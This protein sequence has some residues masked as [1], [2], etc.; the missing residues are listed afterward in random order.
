MSNQKNNN[1]ENHPPNIQ[2]TSEIQEEHEISSEQPQ[3]R[4]TTSLSLE[5]EP[6]DSF[7]SL[8]ANVEEG[9]E[10]A[11]EIVH[12]RTSIT[13]YHSPRLSIST[14][15]RLR[16]L[17]RSSFTAFFVMI[18]THFEIGIIR[19]WWALDSFYFLINC[20]LISDPKNIYHK[21]L[22][23]ISHIFGGLALVLFILILWRTRLR[24][25]QIAFIILYELITLYL[26]FLV[27]PNVTENMITLFST[28]ILFCATA[29][30]A[31]YCPVNITFILKCFRVTF[32]IVVRSHE[33]V[34]Y[35]PDNLW[36]LH[37]EIHNG[38]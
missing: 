1:N 14:I 19:M 29:I 15:A 38:V 21:K 6:S 8:E 26:P 31:D 13:P 4:K 11:E 34:Y 7:Y 24:Y 10:I 33:A 3:V 2:G 16:F 20:L 12:H 25:S 28:T 30:I 36:I 18:L 32:I 9:A 22:F 5:E 17:M 27:Q 23:F 37:R 35:Y